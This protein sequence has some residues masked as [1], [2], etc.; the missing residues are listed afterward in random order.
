MRLS[1]KFA[2]RKQSATALLL[3]FEM[4]TAGGEDPSVHGFM[5]DMHVSE[6]AFTGI[7]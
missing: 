5:P 6:E 1:T 7:A 3:A 4:T 2:T